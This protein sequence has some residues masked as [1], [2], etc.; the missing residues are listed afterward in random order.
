MSPINYWLDFPK[1]A[2]KDGYKR[3][4]KST[5][6]SMT[7]NVAIFTTNITV[8]DC[9]EDTFHVHVVNLIRS[10]K[11]LRPDGS[12]Y[13][14]NQEMGSKYRYDYSSIGNNMEAS[15]FVKLVKV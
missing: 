13:L 4:Y 5:T 9:P 7:D 6:L 3:T 15:I 2:T 10:A 11:A 8:F 1:S 14:Y 12:G